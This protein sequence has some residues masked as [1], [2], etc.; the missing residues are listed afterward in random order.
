[1]SKDHSLYPSVIFNFIEILEPKKHYESMGCDRVMATIFRHDVP[2]PGGDGFAL[3]QA[4][5]LG[6]YRIYSGVRAL[7]ASPLR[8]VGR[9]AVHRAGFLDLRRRLLGIGG[10]RRGNQADLRLIPLQRH[11]WSETRRCASNRSAS[12]VHDDLSHHGWS[13]AR[14]SAVSIHEAKVFVASFSRFWLPQNAPASQ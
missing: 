5:R 8:R 4:P 13:D 9:P 2:Y 1:M 6:Q 11:A 14:F 7:C 3:V 12:L 10:G